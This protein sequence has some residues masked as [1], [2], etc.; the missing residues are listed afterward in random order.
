ML[1]SRLRRR[2]PT[3]AVFKRQHPMGNYILDFFCPAARLC[4]EIDGHGHGDAAHVAHDARRDGWLRTQGVLV[5]RIPASSVFEDVDDV[6]DGVAAAG[7][8][9][10]GKAGMS[11]LRLLFLPRSAEDGGG[12]AP[13]RGRDGG[14]DQRTAP[15]RAPSTTRSSAGGPPPPSSAERGRKR[16][17]P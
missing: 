12:G 14:G 2:A 1:W 17:S 11:R 5:H 3:E 4:V 13:R 10:H 9:T 8:R 16:M 7:E 15:S 6:A